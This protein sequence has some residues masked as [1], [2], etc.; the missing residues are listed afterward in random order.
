MLPFKRG[1]RN[2]WLRLLQSYGVW[3]E[4]TY[5]ALPGDAFV[6]FITHYSGSGNVLAMFDSVLHI[7]L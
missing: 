5:I 6:M 4:G 2:N 7:T 1:V 3:R